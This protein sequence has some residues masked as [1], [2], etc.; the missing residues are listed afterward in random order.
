MLIWVNM[1]YPT[2]MEYNNNW[3][4]IQQIIVSVCLHFD[5]STESMQWY[6]Y[7][8]DGTHEYS[9]LALSPSTGLQQQEQLPRYPGQHS[10]DSRAAHVH[11]EPGSGHETQC[12][13]DERWRWENQISFKAID[14]LH[15]IQYVRDWL[16]RSKPVR[17]DERIPHTDRPEPLVFVHTHPL[18][19]S[20]R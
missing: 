14:L 19:Q 6:M 15:H 20:S 5:I 9:S 8:T 18:E 16:H 4:P 13:F 7:Y 12:S 2:S 3:R 1:V 17:L 11:L 10:L